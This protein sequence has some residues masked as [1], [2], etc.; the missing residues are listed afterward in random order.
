MILKTKQL[1]KQLQL[2]GGL[3]TINVF[4]KNN[5]SSTRIRETCGQQGCDISVESYR[6]YFLR[7]RI[8]ETYI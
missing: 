4:K 7:L 3:V 6:L 2:T 1:E 5:S 8:Q